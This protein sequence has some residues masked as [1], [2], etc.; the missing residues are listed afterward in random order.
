[1]YVGGRLGRKNCGAVSECRRKASQPNLGSKRER[2]EEK[3][4]GTEREAER[5][6]WYGSGNQVGIR[7]SRSRTSVKWEDDGQDGARWGRMMGWTN[8]GRFL[9]VQDDTPVFCRLF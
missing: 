5:E 6:T 4:R 9:F 1:M 3:V 7:S 8:G 2:K